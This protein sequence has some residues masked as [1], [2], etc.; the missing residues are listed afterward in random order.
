MPNRMP[1]TLKRSPPKAQKTY[2]KT[3]ENAER[4]YGNGERASRTAYAALKHTFEKVGDHWEPK[5]KP[6]PSDP[7]ARQSAHGGRRTDQGESFG[8]VDV[9]GHTRQE[10]LDR[11]RAHGIDVNTRMTKAEIA[12]RLARKQG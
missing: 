11:A 10:L 3:L 6:G 12:R 7:R 5:D 8:G 2:A 9:E 1:G 4:E